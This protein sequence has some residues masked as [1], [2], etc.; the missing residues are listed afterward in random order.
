MTPQG[1]TDKAA[2]I[3]HIAN[4]AFATVVAAIIAFENVLNIAGFVRHNCKTNKIIQTTEE[5]KMED[6]QDPSRITNKSLYL[7]MFH[8]RQSHEMCSWD[9]D[10]FCFCWLQKIIKSSQLQLQTGSVHACRTVGLCL[11]GPCASSPAICRRSETRLCSGRLWRQ[12]PVSSAFV[13][14]L[15]TFRFRLHTRTR[16]FKVSPLTSG[17]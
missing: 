8:V 12:P 4:A 5:I 10:A 9:E 13:T 7:S 6:V 15:K 11:A 16:L 14:A 1:P 3:S 17:R 2:S